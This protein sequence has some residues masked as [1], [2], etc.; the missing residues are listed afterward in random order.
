M[1]LN[2]RAWQVAAR[3]ADAADAFRV[4]TWA[5]ADARVFDC[6]VAAPGGLHAG[7]ELARA[8]LA[9]LAEV[10]VTPPALDGLPFPGVQVSTD[11]PVRACLQ[12]QYAGW[13]IAVGKYFAMGS[14]PMRAKYGGEKL[15][16]DVG[17]REESPVAVGVLESRKLPAEEVITYLTE[18][19][20]LSASQLTLLVAPVTSLAGTVQVVAR[21]LETALHKLHELHFDL[22]QVVAG[23]GV[24]PLPPPVADELQALGRTNDAILYGGRAVVWVAG[25]D[26]AVAALGPK[27][28]SGASPDHGT[29]FAEIFA[30]YNHDF[31][32]IDPLLFSPAQITFCNLRSGRSHT[33]GTL[34]PAVL[35]KSFGV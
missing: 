4:Q 3:L 26:E 1:M 32:Q 16:D 6:G 8:C 19:L 23:H 22:A 25:D 21:C 14:G 29:P 7:L 17:G 5:V 30:R 28:P 2:D 24:A 13:Q 33:F 18:K 10:S 27:V 20:K 34:A 11:H 31:Y 35:R 12:S 15:F 9:D